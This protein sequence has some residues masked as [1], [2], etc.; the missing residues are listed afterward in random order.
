MRVVSRGLPSSVFTFPLRDRYLPPCLCTMSWAEAGSVGRHPFIVNHLDVCD[1]VNR[2]RRISC[3]LPRSRIEHK[4][5]PAVLHHI[6]RASERAVVCEWV[7]TEFVR[8]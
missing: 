1:Q 3:G 8:P 5:D 4:P 6:L 7:T 2:H